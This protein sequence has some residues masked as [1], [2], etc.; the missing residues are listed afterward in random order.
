MTG[1]AILSQITGDSP[2]VRRSDPETSHAA[3]DS[4]DADALEA[5]EVEVLA[6]LAAAARP[7]TAAAIERENLERAWQ[8]RT[9]RAWSPSRIR[10]ALRQR[11]R[12]GDIV[13]DGEG[14]TPSGRRAAAWR[15]AGSAS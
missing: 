4:I 6:I 1:P 2:R 3:A 14:R 10:T 7:M 15:L 11:A 5:S 12:D 13:Q 8:G 9:E